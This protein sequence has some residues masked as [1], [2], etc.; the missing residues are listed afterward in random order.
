M[1]RIVFLFLATFILAASAAGLGN[2]LGDLTKKP[3]ATP[4]PAPQ[5]PTPVRK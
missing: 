5:S 4:Q 2:L 3:P 1:K